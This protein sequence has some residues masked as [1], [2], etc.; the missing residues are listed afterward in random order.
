MSG[1]TDNTLKFWDLARILRE[2]NLPQEDPRQLPLQR[3][4][5]KK[6]EV[7]EDKTVVE[8]LGKTTAVAVTG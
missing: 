8:L 3:K 6:K 2:K 5:K 1:A 7:V 4:R